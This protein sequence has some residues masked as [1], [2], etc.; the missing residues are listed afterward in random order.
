MSM[1][2]EDFG[3][4]MIEGE[5]GLLTTGN[6]QNCVERMIYSADVILSPQVFLLCPT[7]H[8]NLVIIAVG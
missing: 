2:Y 3:V 5:K 7:K 4:C 6:R 8:T 1:K